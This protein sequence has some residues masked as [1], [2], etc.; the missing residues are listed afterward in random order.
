MKVEILTIGDELLRG[1]II[2]TNKA[3][4]AAKLLSCD[5]EVQHQVSVQDDPDTMLE[6]FRSAASRS[7]LILI[8]GGLGPTSD[9]LTAEV[10]AKAFC[11]RLVVHQPSLDAIRAFFERKT[12]GTRPMAESNT[13]QAYFPEG[14]EVLPNAI[15]TAPGFRLEV[16]SVHLICMPGVPRELDLMMDTH[17]L[18]WIEKRWPGRSVV[19]E[20]RLRTFGVG[21]S[22]IE[23]QLGGLARGG[24]PLGDVRLGYRT[25]F[26]DNFLR[27]VA[28]ASTVQEAQARL[29]EASAKIRHLLGPLVYAEGEV[30]MEQLLC[31]LLRAEGKTVAVGESCT[32]GLVSELITSIPGSSEVFLGGVVAYSNR[33][34]VEFLGVSE[35]LLNTHGA[36]S[37]QVARVM[38]EGVRE[39]FMADFGLASTGVAGP[40][41]GTTE[42]PVGLVYLA[43]AEKSRATRVEKLELPFPRHLHRRLCAQI[44]FDGLRRRLLGFEALGVSEPSVEKSVRSTKQENGLG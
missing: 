19:C 8:S 34:K 42:K 29:D 33:A 37:E 15:G 21:E 7:D 22:S 30:E 17:V 12:S 16:G 39:R 6:A 20:R 35:A 2:D 28:H 10:I 14:A 25:A 26:P 27:L 5:I 13:K 18:P 11:R 36:V 1:E 9:D 4:I 40:G 41:G 3:R 23:D 44:L 38:A 43:W 32:G 24:G 31:E